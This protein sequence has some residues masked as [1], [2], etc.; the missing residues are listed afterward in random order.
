MN[1]IR[2]FIRDMAKYLPSRIVPAAVGLLVIPIVTRLFPPA[3]YGNYVLV[4]ATASILS[5]VSTGWLGNSII[6]FHPRYELRE[7]LGQFY[8]TVLKMAFVSMACASFIFLIILFLG[9]GRMSSSL[10][11]LMYLGFPVFIVIA[12]SGILQAFLRAKRQVNWYTFFSIWHSVMGSAVGIALVMI[13]HFGIEG[14]LWGGLSTIVIALPL[15]WKLAVGKGISLKERISWPITSEIAKYGFPL[16]GGFLTSWVLS[17]SDRY[18]LQFF[19]GGQEVGIYSASY[20]FSEH[21]IFM[22]SHLFILA[23][24]PISM[25][26]W[27]KQGVQ[28]SQEF[29]T[30]LTRY[31]LFICL[32]A[33][34]GLS[35]L[36]KPI[37]NV[38]VAPEYYQGYTIIPLVAGGALLCSLGYE[39]GIPLMWHNKTHIWLACSTGGSVLNIGLNL[40]LVPKYGY[41]AAALTTL[42]SYSVYGFLVIV[43]SRI[44]LVWKFPF[45]FLGKATI[46]STVMGVAAYCIADNLPSSILS[47]FVATTAGAIIYL[48]VLFLMR[49]FSQLDEI[50][51]VMTWGRK[52]VKH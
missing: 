52:M 2:E 1:V 44:F 10:Y 28:A 11:S 20:K 42:I 49:G 27:E 36:A 19:R 3:D 8:N 5:S 43:A 17:F 34:V 29:L 45:R 41:T 24:S 31:F 40:L 35:V 25:N 14:L 12:C 38:M 33:T 39:Y 51:T 9:H 7:R 30:K 6:R 16:T 4:M 22:L 47:L 26:V 50:G 48:V 37:I 13:W 15:L 46:A 23:S 32:P 18:I 21:I